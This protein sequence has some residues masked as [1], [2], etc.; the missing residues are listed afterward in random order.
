MFQRFHLLM[1][2]Y[3][4][5]R[6]ALGSSRTP[7]KVRARVSVSPHGRYIRCDPSWIMSS[8]LEPHRLRYWQT[9]EHCF[10]TTKGHGSISREHEQIRGFV[11]SRQSRQVTNPRIRTRSAFRAFSSGG[12]LLFFAGHRGEYQISFIDRCFAKCVQQIQRP[13]PLL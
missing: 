6:E 8:R 3:F 11:E 13:L 5:W 12:E 9:A 1:D 10:Q 7:R 2:A 4:N